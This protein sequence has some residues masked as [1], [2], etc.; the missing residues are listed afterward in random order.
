[1]IRATGQSPFYLL[2]ASFAV[3]LEFQSWI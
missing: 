2:P 3:R 1:L